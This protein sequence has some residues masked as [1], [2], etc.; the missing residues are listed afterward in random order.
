MLLRYTMHQAM[1]SINS[2]QA[3]K[4][5][6]KNS[7]NKKSGNT[8]QTTHDWKHQTPKFDINILHQVSWLQVI[9]Q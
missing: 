9:E 3:D 7:D 6:L 1:Y 8:F 4:F 5:S 2:K